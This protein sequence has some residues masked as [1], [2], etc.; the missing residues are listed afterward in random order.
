[1]KYITMTATKAVIG[2]AMLMAASM[3]ATAQSSNSAKQTAANTSKIVKQLGE[4]SKA[5]AKTAEA[6][7]GIVETIKYGPIDGGSMRANLT[8]MYDLPFQMMDSQNP[9][10][11]YIGQPAPKGVVVYM[12]KNSKVKK[13]I[14]HLNQ[15][16]GVFGKQYK[17][18][19]SANVGIVQASKCNDFTPNGKP[20]CYLKDMFNKP[21][22]DPVR[23]DKVVCEYKLTTAEPVK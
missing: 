22:R 8:K 11:R 7:Q 21:L 2:A 16:C 6:L 3:P 20:W 4:I 13:L 9:L 1:M 18:M 14:S 23:I 19:Y 5:N 15:Y 12:G 10:D 17:A